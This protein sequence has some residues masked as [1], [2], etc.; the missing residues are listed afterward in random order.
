M[1]CITLFTLLKYLFDPTL[2]YFE[3]KTWLN[4][5]DFL[6]RP[7]LNLGYLE[8]LKDY[9]LSKYFK[10]VL[11]FERIRTND[12]DKKYYLIVIALL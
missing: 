12:Q 11:F 4:S 2:R 1:C 8:V 5:L 3:I 6:E 7:R 10:T 9:S